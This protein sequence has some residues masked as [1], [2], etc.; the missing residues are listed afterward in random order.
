MNPIRPVMGRDLVGSS[1]FHIE[2]R[3]LSNQNFKQWSLALGNLQTFY[4]SNVVVISS[5]MLFKVFN[6]NNS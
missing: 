1:E 3:I 2:W 4:I 5:K 6:N